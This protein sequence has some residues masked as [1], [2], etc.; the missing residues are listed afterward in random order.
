M[1]NC[2]LGLRHCLFATTSLFAS[3]REA[4][5]VEFTARLTIPACECTVQAVAVDL[6]F[7]PKLATCTGISSNLILAIPQAKT[8]SL[9]AELRCNPGS[10]SE[11]T[12]D[13]E[14]W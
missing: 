11:C 3:S 7:R 6:R 14:A 5:S 12:D 4:I 2:G 10:D 1:Q 13:S 8:E 9:P